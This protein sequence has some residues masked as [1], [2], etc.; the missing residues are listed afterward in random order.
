LVIFGLLVLNTTVLV[1]P[2]TVFNTELPPKFQ[3]LAYNYLSTLKS[4]KY[5]PNHGSDHGCPSIA[6]PLSSVAILLVLLFW[7]TESLTSL[8]TEPCPGPCSLSSPLACPVG[9]HFWWQKTL[10][11]PKIWI[12][13]HSLKAFANPLNWN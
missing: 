5:F 12:R 3:S 1:T 9:I 10:Q 8:H 6:C 2:K 7:P 13:C 4:G 11:V